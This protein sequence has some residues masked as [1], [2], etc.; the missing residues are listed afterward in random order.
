MDKPKFTRC[1]KDRHGTERWR[2]KRLT[3]QI[4][5]PGRPGEPAFEIAYRDALDGGA[6][7]KAEVVRLEPRTL[8]SAWKGV[9]GTHE[10]K[11]LDPNTQYQNTKFAEGFLRR[12]LFEGALVTWADF[13]V[14][15]LRH[16]HIKELLNELFERKHT[17]T[18]VL[19]NLRRMIRFALDKEWIDQDPSAMISWKPKSKGHRAWTDDERH[20]FV[21]VWPIGTRPHLAY[22]LAYYTGQRR[23]DVHR[24]RWT[25][26]DGGMLD[27]I[28][29]KT[30][31]PVAF[32]LLPEL[33]EVLAAT[34]HVHE[35]V[36]TSSWGRP[37]TADSLS[38]RVTEWTRAAGLS[39]CT[40]HGLR[41]TMGARLAD[42]EATTS[43]IQAVLGHTT[44]AQASLYT[45]A[46]DRR[47]N[48]RSGMLK[49]V[50]KK[51]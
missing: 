7:R 22:A 5:L 29:K 18:R 23:S 26:L 47:R 42:E 19:I 14:A 8:A 39:G 24:I 44:L 17:A 32:G 33:E 16:K 6:R 51:G 12:P 25:D 2:F 41:K 15:D 13:P 34:P 27:I 46:A 40:L 36:L 37:Y 48:G 28:Q 45:Q 11:E 38:Q 49:L 35:V 43:Q 1:Y 10:W 31:M 20:A 50:N 21:E 9:K 4:E 30:K 3:V